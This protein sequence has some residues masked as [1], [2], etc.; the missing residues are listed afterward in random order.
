MVVTSNKNLHNN[1][2]TV[3][4]Y[5][6]DRYTNAQKVNT[7]SAISKGKCKKVISYSP[8]DIDAV[9]GKK[10]KEFCNKLEEGVSGFCSAST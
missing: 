6:D 1:G 10:T 2:I 5:S 7:K 4:N 9:F 8:K 3:V